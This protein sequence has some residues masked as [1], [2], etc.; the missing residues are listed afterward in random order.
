MK[1]GLRNTLILILTLILIVG[2]GWY[3][4]EFT[5]N[6]QIED[7]SDELEV[8][9]NELT[10]VREFSE[11][12]ANAQAMY[13]DAVFIR[14][15]H[16][17]ELF[18]N[19]NTSQIYNYL[20]ELNR[21]E[22]FTELNFNFTDSLQLEDH[23]IINVELQGEGNYQNLVNFLYRI[24]HSRPFIKINSVALQG[25]SDAERLNR[26]N[27]SVQLGAYYRRGNWSEFTAHPETVSSPSDRIHN[28]YYPLIHSVPAN[29]DNLPD[30]DNSR[31]IVLTG[32]T[33]HI[34]DQN[35]EMKRLNVGDRVYLGRLASINIERGEALFQLN[36]GG[37]ADRIILTLDQ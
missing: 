36:R 12:Y 20:Q 6:S 14:E 15:N 21:S 17:K 10:V 37:I 34:I 27:Y 19:S 18:L 7:A 35:G 2:G 32:T 13:V 4:L 23:G 9:E 26:V 30:V 8:V 31:L 29:E 24:E 16:P 5:Y 22:S 28:P 33:A 25:I 1:Q 11:M 3:Y